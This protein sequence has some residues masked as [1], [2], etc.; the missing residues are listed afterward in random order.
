VF[1]ELLAD[2]FDQFVAGDGVVAQREGDAE[3]VV[4]GG[5]ELVEG[6]HVDPF[7]AVQAREEAGQA[8]HRLGVVGPAG[9][10]DAADPRPFAEP[11]QA[12]GEV[13]GGVSS[14][15]VGSRWVVTSKD[16]MSSSTRSVS[17]RSSPEAR[18]P[19]EAG[20]VQ[21]RV[22]PGLL[23]AAQHGTGE[24]GLQQRLAAGDGHP[25]ARRPPWRRRRGTCRSPP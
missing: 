13:E 10:Q 14:P 16:L 25:A 22:Q 21:C 20:G 24:V 19:E 6:Q 12:G 17:A 3:G 7:G 23:A 4:L 8:V 18:A 11:V 9:H 15:P 2:P 5:A 1:P